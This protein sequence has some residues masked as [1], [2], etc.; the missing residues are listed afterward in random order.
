MPDSTKSPYSPPASEFSATAPCRCGF[1]GQG[2]HPCHGQAYSC[3]KAATA[4][5][6]AQSTPYSLAGMQL[7]VAATQTWACDICWE[8]FRIIATQ[9]DSGHDQQQQR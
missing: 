6:V 4:R 1:T 7:K 2:D 3:R 8:T 5:F 9:K